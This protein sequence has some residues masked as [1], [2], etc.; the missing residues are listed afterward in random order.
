MLK[1]ILFTVYLL[2]SKSEHILLCPTVSV[3]KTKSK[4]DNNDE[5]KYTT[6]FL[7]RIMASYKF[8]VILFVDFIYF[9]NSML[10]Q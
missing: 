6:S 8:S 3:F 10:I 4:L 5:Y 1:L 7:R 9:L 2:E